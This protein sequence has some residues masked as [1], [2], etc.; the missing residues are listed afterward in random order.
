MVLPKESCV[1]LPSLDDQRKYLIAKGYFPQGTTLSDD[2][3]DMLACS[4]FHYLLGYF[5]NYNKYKNKGFLPEQPNISDVLDIVRMDVKVSSL[6]YEYMRQSEQAIRAAWVHVFCTH[7]SPNEYLNPDAYI[8]M[9]RKKPVDTL[10]KDMMRHILRYR[11]PYVRERIE[12]WWKSCARTSSKNPS[13]SLD[14]WKDVEAL[15][16]M[17]QKELPLWSVVDSFSLGLLSRAVVQSYALETSTESGDAEKLLLY[18]KTAEYMGVHHKHFGVRLKSLTT[19]R[20][21]VAHGSRLWM[22]PTTDTSAKPNMF[23]DDLSEADPKGML[24]SFANVALLQG[25]T[26][27]QREAWDAIKDLVEQNQSYCVGVGSQK[28]FEKQRQSRSYLAL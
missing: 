26:R 11:E 28:I 14:D 1:F 13:E 20:N 4:N 8:C 27:R 25:N 17:M 12:Q 24:V 9:D 23:T 10:I 18:K 7:R 21:R 6:M 19:L 16:E 5:R 22:M 3:R 2:D 15:R